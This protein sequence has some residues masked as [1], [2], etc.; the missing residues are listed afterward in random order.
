MKP[1]GKQVKTEDKKVH[2]RIKE[3]S[4]VKSRHKEGRKQE[5]SSFFLDNSK[6]A[7]QI[8]MRV[9]F[10]PEGYTYKKGQ[11]AH[12]WAWSTRKKAS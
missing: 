6:P 8:K 11:M 9:C 4:Q 10:L 12:Y 2:S 3:A 5:C 7:F 1:S